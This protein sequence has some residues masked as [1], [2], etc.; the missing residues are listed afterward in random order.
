MRLWID[1]DVGT[2]P[3]DAIAL[4]CAA[5]HRDVD[6]VGVSTVDSDTERRAEI[7]RTLVDAPV[8]AGAHLSIRDVRAS[9]A[10]ALLAI[11]P[12]E[13]VARLLAA[14]ALPPRLGVMGGVLRPIRHRGAVRDVEHNFGAEPAAT[15]AV[16]DHAPGLLVC[17]L[18]VTVRMRPSAADTEAMVDAVPVL[19]PMIDGWRRRQQTAAVPEDEAA[20]RLHDPLALFA[21]VGEPVVAIEQ[22]RLTVDARARLSEDRGRGRVA[23]VVTDVDVVRAMERIVT[24]VAQSSRSA[25]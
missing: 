18:D 2:N 13:N 3:D 10:E 1:S 17:P 9:G 14:G 12:L 5:S 8:I 24:L 16:I 15:R 7:A 11:G 25:Q 21:L 23:D 20:V 22:R 4:V 6:L 19:G